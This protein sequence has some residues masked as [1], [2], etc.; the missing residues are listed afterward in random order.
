VDA[1]TSYYYYPTFQSFSGYVAITTGAS[2]ANKKSVTDK[3][4]NAL[5]AAQIAASPA[6][7]AGDY[8]LGAVIFPY[9]DSTAQEGVPVLIKAINVSGQNVGAAGSVTAN[10]GF[11]VKTQFFSEDFSGGSLPAGWA[12]LNNGTCTDAWRFD[13][14]GARDLFD[15]NFAIADSDFTGL[16]PC[17]M[18]AS[19]R[20]P[21]IDASSCTAD[22][23][24][25]L[26]DFANNFVDYGYGA[27]GDVNVTTDGFSNTATVLSLTSAIDIDPKS[28]DITADVIANPATT[29]VE[30][31]YH[32]AYYA[33]WWG[34]D[35]VSLSC[36][37]A[38]V[39]SCGSPTF[40][41]DG[42]YPDQ[43]AGDGIFAAMFT[44]GTGAPGCTGTGLYSLDVNINGS[45]VETLK[46]N[47]VAGAT[48]GVGAVLPDTLNFAFVPVGSSQSQPIHVRNNGGV[49]FQITGATKASGV[50]YTF[51]D[52]GGTYPINVS[53]G[54]QVNGSVTFTPT[55]GG[56]LSDTLTINTDIGD[57]FVDMSGTGVGPNGDIHVT[58]TAVNFGTAGSGTVQS[59]DLTVSNTG[60]ADLHISGIDFPDPNLSS[61][62]TFPITV[63]PAGST[64]VNVTWTAPAVDAALD[65]QAVLVSD[66]PDESAVYIH[67]FG[68][69]LAC[70]FSDDY[71][72]A[73]IDPTKWTVLRNTFSQAG[74][75]LT[76]SSLAKKAKIIA[77]GFAGC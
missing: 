35:D 7:T 10:V 64:T 34:I 17:L 70:S 55:I 19:L 37:D 2:E 38:T 69:S 61:S 71:A 56:L 29:Q 32:N 4:I 24:N 47:V 59:A 14:P 62:S 30:F 51:N 8:N 1:V 65:V 3:R 66:D 52:F 53:P 49:A 21:V 13:D 63:P 58:P 16:P 44:P 57:L 76:G 41:D 26:L 28:V 11:Q 18:D 72:G 15:D 27:V 39:V 12:N 77:T 6:G 22:G 23:D 67:V 54:G 31:R 46:F 75:D 33:F 9:T 36:L 43:I 60:P 5:R 48:P 68:T 25:V 20:T 74:G 40:L 42:V 50:D 45:P 73:V